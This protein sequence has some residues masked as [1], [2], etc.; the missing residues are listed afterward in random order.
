MFSGSM[1]DDSRHIIHYSRC[2]IENLSDAP[3]YVVTHWSLGVSFTIVVLIKCKPLFKAFFF[4]LARAKA[5][6]RRTALQDK[7]SFQIMS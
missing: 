3:N 7:K 1:I 4:C 6:L 2:K 5:F